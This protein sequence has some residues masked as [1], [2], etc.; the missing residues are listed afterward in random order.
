MKYVFFGTPAF[1]A[2]VLR[3]LMEAGW[4]P[5][6][7]VCNPDRPFG[8]KK[9]VAPPPTKQLV[10]NEKLENKIGILQPEHLLPLSPRLSTFQPDFFIVAA[11]AVMIPKKILEIPRVGTIGVHPSLLPKYRGPT[12]IQNAILDGERETGISL[13]L[14]DEK[15]DHGPIIAQEKLAIENASYEILEQKLGT[16]AGSLLLQIIP[17]MLDGSIDPKPQAEDRAT[18][19]KKFTS[20]DGFVEYEDLQAAL[21]GKNKEIASRIERKV[22]ALNPEP[23]VWALREGKRLKILEARMNGDRLEL[24]KI[25]TEG[26]KPVAVL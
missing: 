17:R 22:R 13:Y 12:P 8:R 5:V 23:G 18:Y 9:I 20:Q 6:A 3:I 25:Q 4:L 11:Y 1:A 26:K 24:K 15:L 21:Q 2:R 19:T 10:R 16:V 7:L 14:M